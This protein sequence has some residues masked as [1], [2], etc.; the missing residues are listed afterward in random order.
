M[1]RTAV[2]TLTIIALL[3]CAAGNAGALKYRKR[4]PWM[5]NV[6]IGIGTGKFDDYDEVTREW[7]TGA[8]PQIR[9]GR[10]IGRH[11]MISLNYQGWLIEFD[12]Y[13]DNELED[14]KIRRSLQDLAFGI[15]WFP[16]NPEGPWGGLYLRAGGGMG[17]SGTAV[18]PV[19]EGGKQEHGYRQDDWGTA[20]FGEVGYEFWISDNA[21]IGIVTSYTYFDIQGRIVQT[22]W[23]TAGGITLA[24]YF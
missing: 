13:G 14:A 18:I 9:L 3:S 5:V 11:F 7:R 16:G 2:I 17:W 12:R 15:A 22:A 23:V 19:E 1:K 24:L 21:T 6:G 10:M 20:W 4:D 8:V